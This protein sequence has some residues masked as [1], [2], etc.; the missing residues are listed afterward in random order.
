ME[1]QH[2]SF[3]VP[4]TAVAVAHAR[5]RVVAGICGWGLPVGSSVV[6]TVALVTSELLTNAVQHAGHGP[7]SVA[8][9]LK[10]DAVRV[11]V[12]DSSRAL[13]KPSLSDEDD[14]HGRGLFIVAALAVRHDVETTESGKRCWAEIPVHNKPT[15]ATSPNT[16]PDNA[17]TSSLPNGP[18]SRWAWP[19]PASARCLP[20]AQRGAHRPNSTGTV[21]RVV[22]SRRV[23]LPRAMNPVERPSVV[24]PRPPLLRL[25]LSCAA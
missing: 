24:L 16:S 18:G 25:G 10:G 8:A 9:R 6:E 13:P 17:S 4:G 22:G 1:S 7:V 19:P 14:E 20:K 12:C 11:E 15:S 2:L 23:G 3:S 21:L 5:H